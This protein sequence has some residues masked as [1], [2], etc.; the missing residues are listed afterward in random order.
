MTTLRTA[1]PLAAFT[2]EEIIDKGPP[3]VRLI[4]GKVNMAGYI[5]APYGSWP[6]IKK[7]IATDVTHSSTTQNACTSASWLPVRQPS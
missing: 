3:L 4:C 7:L 5:L 1:L 2:T 6:S